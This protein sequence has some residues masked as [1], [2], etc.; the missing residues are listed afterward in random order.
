M[1][2]A[3]LLTR[4]NVQA[5]LDSIRQEGKSSNTVKKYTRD[6]GVFEEF[7]FGSEAGSRKVLCVKP[8]TQPTIAAYRQ[9]LQAN[10]SPT[11]ANSML[12]PLNNLLK[13]LG[14]AD[15][16]ARLFK[17]QRRIFAAA[18]RELS[19]KDY[20]KLIEAASSTGKLHLRLIMETM[21]ATGMRVSE[22]RHV[23][24]ESV[25]D[26]KVEFCSKGKIREVYFPQK[27]RKNLLN[28]ARS[29]GITEG[30][31][32]RT[33]CGNPVDRSNLYH[34]MKKLAGEAGVSEKKVFPHNFRHLFAR[35]FYEKEKD[36]VALADILGH[37]NLQ[38]TRI[39]TMTSVSEH[40]DKLEHLGLVS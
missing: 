38:T 5:Y 16:C 14:R 7:V 39:Y 29:K 22:I 2:K 25:G 32:F 9:Y 28:Y 34:D 13:F 33:R 19:R 30:P 23:T 24:V 6:L 3:L 20:E 17:V 21:A 26:G 8:V 40:I 36:I 11:S 1:R 10:Y 4:A 12:A 15:L 35:I 37:S 31:I 18:D 27:L